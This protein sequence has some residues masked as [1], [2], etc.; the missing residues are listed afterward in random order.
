MFSS[1]LG[2][3]TFAIYWREPR[4]P[5]ECDQKIIGQITPLAA[6]AIDLTGFLIYAEIAKPRPTSSS[7]WELRRSSDAGFLRTRNRG[8]VCD[9][10]HCGPDEHLRQVP[11][12]GDVWIA[13]EHGA[14]V[15]RPNPERTGADGL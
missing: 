14:A 3:G 12:P 15:F 2:L 10:R 9:S 1:G 6:V 4:M 7:S 13:D 11:E 5:S 8:S